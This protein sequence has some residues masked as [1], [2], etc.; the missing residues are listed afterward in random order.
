[1]NV[2]SPRGV[3]VTYKTLL[4]LAIPALAMVPL[5]AHAITLGTAGDFAV[6]AGSTVTNTGPTVINGG[7]VGV[8]AGTAITGFPAG[9]VSAPFTIHSA[10]AVAL[11][12]QNDL[13]TA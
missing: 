13:T 11:Q 8:S 1:M 10:D 3:I 2:H 4:L 12:A 6:L 5:Q 9:I 7:N